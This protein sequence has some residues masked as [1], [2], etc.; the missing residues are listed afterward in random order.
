MSEVA[1]VFDL[2]STPAGPLVVEDDPGLPRLEVD[3]AAPSPDAL[4]QARYLV[5][6]GQ[7]TGDPL[8]HGA[9]AE[10]RGLQLP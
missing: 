7:G 5:E 10:V 4:P 9:G 2:T 8:A 6:R 3:G 1:L